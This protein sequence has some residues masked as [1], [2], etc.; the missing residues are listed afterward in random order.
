M[1]LVISCRIKALRFSV[2]SDWFSI[3]SI[4]SILA[5]TSFPRIRG[6]SPVE[7][8]Y[9]PTE[10]HGGRMRRSSFLFFYLSLDEDFG[11]SDIERRTRGFQQQSFFLSIGLL[12]FPKWCANFLN[13]VTKKNDYNKARSKINHLPVLGVR[14]AKSNFSME[15]SSPKKTVRVVQFLYIFLFY[16]IFL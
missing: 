9:T 10:E 8:S 3:E 5:S 13:L 6:I 4:V 15:R 16:I 1:L 2:F 12:N 14:V 7:V 11:G